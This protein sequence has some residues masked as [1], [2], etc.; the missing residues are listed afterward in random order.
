MK[1]VKT[2]ENYNFKNMKILKEVEA[3]EKLDYLLANYE[4]A[5]FGDKNDRV[6]GYYTIEDF[7]IAFDNTTNNCWVE[8]F[9]T[10]ENAINF[11][12]GKETEDRH[13]NIVG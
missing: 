10:K 11:C 2:F 12:M 6:S 5:P 13:G 3:K 7:Y 9:S 4:K 8:E 1:Y